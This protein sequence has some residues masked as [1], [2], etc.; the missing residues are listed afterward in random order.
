YQRKLAKPG[1]TFSADITGTLN[2]SDGNAML[3]TQKILTT[4]SDTAGLNQQANFYSRS[5]TVQA[6]FAYT[7]PVTPLSQMQFSYAPYFVQ[8]LRDRNTFDFD[9]F[10]NNYENLNVLLSNLFLNYY[11]T[12]KAG[13]AYRLRNNSDALNISVG[14]NMQFALLT[15]EQIFP[16]VSKVKR[17][18][19][20]L[21]PN[22]TL[23]YR[24]ARQGNLRINYTTSTNPPTISQL[25]NILDNS[26]PLFLNIGNPSLKQDY[27]HNL[28]IRFNNVDTATMHMYFGFMSFTYTQ[29]AIGNS[30]IIALKDTIVLSDILVPAGTQF[31]R[32]VNFSRS[33]SFRSFF[34]YNFPIKKI[35][36][37]FSLL[38]GISYVQLP[39]LINAN[40]NIS[41]TTNLMSGFNLSSNISE[42][43][44]FNIYYMSNYNIV[45]NTLRKEQNSNFFFH[46]AEARLNWNFWKGF[47]LNTTWSN[48]LYSGIAQGFNQN[49][50]LWN[51]SLAYRFFSNRS[52]ELKFGVFDILGQNNS[53]A[54]N[55]NETFI[56]DTR[57]DVLQRYYLITLTYNIRKFKK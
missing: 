34:G 19:H 32:P 23:T 13:F 4:D 49:F 52:L 15:G 16:D 33:I 12:H 20:D 1:R 38:G 5:Y 44:D 2:K 6:T 22:A 11:T 45:R 30:T 24:F 14:A 53:I 55:V 9:T 8:N 42:K 21:L 29:N 17:T 57:T 25:Q 51:A 36:L 26:N 54:R 48:T 39:G 27:R 28:V 43:I 37:N 35:K 40:L 31:T 50:L 10:S 7:E 46:N 56:E 47:V 41:H 3:L 18:F